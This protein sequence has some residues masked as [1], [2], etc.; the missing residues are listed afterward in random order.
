VDP[1]YFAKDDGIWEKYCE[2]FAQ[3][4]SLEKLGCKQSI[5]ISVGD[6]SP[7]VLVDESDGSVLGYIATDT[8]VLG[9]FILED[10]LKYNPEFAEDMEK[11]PESF[12]V[13]KGFTGDVV[14][15]TKKERYY[16]E[17][18]P[19]TTIMGI[20]TTRFHSGF[21]DDDGSIKLQLSQCKVD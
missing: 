5:C 20:G 13:I 17:V 7:D 19:I 2:D 14:F 8:Y 16:D 4:K 6:V 15:E 3:N 10:V 21:T 12:T 18:L 9:C 1:C 11:Y